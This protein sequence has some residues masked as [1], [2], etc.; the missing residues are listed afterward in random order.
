MFANNN[1]DYIIKQ[2]LN[3]P[4]TTT[5]TLFQQQQ[6][7]QQLLLPTTTNLIENLFNTNNS[8]NNLLT[9]QL[10]QLMIL[11]QQ[12]NDLLYLNKTPLSPVDTKNDQF[13][14]KETPVECLI[15]VENLK[16]ADSSPR[17]VIFLYDF[18]SNPSVKIENLIVAALSLNGVI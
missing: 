18:N 10:L 14:I 2:L 3:A 11:Q 4:L 12:Q 1:D 6:K 7:Q 16:V 8:N 5:T 17:D 9:L 15:K 13:L